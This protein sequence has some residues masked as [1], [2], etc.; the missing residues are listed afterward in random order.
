MGKRSRAS[1]RGTSLSDVRALEMMLDYAIVEGAE[2][3]LP[4]FVLLLR[5]ARLELMTRIGAT[6][7]KTKIEE[8]ADADELRSLAVPLLQRCIDTAGAPADTSSLVTQDQ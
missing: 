3:R 7:R 6:R 1:G 4:L 5:T 8:Q 2:L